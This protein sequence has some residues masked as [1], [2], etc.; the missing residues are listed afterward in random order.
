MP[1]NENINEEMIN[2]TDLNLEEGAGEMPDKDPDTLIAELTAELK[3]QQER[4]MRL[5]AEYDNY[6]KRTQKEQSRLYQDVQAATLCGFLPHSD[7]FARAMEA[8][9]TDPEF[10]KGMALIQTGLE[11]IFARFGVERFGEVGD[12]FDPEIHEAVA[13]MDSELTG[14]DCICMV[15]SPGYRMGERILRPATVAVAN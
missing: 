13:R 5:A 1:H 7:N 10:K 9:T 11:E 4:H 3:E 2:E 8:D 6:R 12:T 14:S 15:F